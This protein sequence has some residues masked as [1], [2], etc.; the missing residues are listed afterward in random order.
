LTDKNTDIDDVKGLLK[1]RQQ[2]IIVEV[3]CTRELEMLGRGRLGYS[4]LQEV[5]SSCG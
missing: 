2:S 3:G 4:F 1:G 5:V